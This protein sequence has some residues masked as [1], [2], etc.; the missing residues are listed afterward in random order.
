MGAKD[1][2]YC[3]GRAWAKTARDNYTLS[4]R[5]DLGDMEIWSAVAAAA[6][7][8]TAWDFEPSFTLIEPH[9]VMK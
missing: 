2:L 8:A 9:I 1:K 6:A 3:L 7:A 5:S 4:M